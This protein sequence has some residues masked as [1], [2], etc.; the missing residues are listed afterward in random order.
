MWRT[1]EQGQLP[2]RTCWTNR[3]TV[4]AGSSSRSRQS[5]PS[6][7]HTRSTARGSS[8]PPGSSLMRATAPAILSAIRGLLLV[9]DSSTT[10][11]T[12]GYVLR[13]CC[14]CS[15]GAG[16]RLILMPL[17][18]GGGWG[19]FKQNKGSHTTGPLV[20]GT[21]YNKRGV[22]ELLGGN[23]DADSVDIAGSWLT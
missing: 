4:A 8:A 21:P 17:G 23:L 22:Y 18:T 19:W 20:I 11:L 9:G 16:L 2:C 10:I 14:N 7:R 12:G 13:E 6:S 15:D 3:A 5:W 1:S